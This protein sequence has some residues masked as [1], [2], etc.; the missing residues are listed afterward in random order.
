MISFVVTK[1][2]MKKTTISE[3]YQLV[4][5]LVKGSE[6]AFYEIYRK[7]YKALYNY[8]LSVTKDA[9]ATTDIVQLVFISVWK[10]HTNVNPELSF[11]AY[12]FTI[13]RNKINNYFREL[14]YNKT[15]QEGWLKTLVT[16]DNCTEETVIFNDYA[17]HLQTAIKALPE[18]KRNIFTLSR[19]NGKSNDEIATITG[20][21][22]HTVK[23]HLS[24]STKIIRQFLLVHSDIYASILIFAHL[25]LK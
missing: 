25:I 18:Q 4:S 22:K 1:T 14:K 8:C 6:K 20:L 2:P 23:N 17:E 11:T 5:L 13:V 19:I 16:A 21:S 24:E 10:N 7:Y 3:D 12:L 15:L 9:E